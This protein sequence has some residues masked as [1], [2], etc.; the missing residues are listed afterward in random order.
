VSVSEWI[1][2]QR[3]RVLNIAGN[4]ETKAPGLQQ[5][6]LVFLMDVLRPLAQR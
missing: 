5:A 4:E 6:A 2:A 1:T 3:V